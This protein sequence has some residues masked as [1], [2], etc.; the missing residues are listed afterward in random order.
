MNHEMLCNPVP[1]ADIPGQFLP[2]PEQQH[3]RTLLSV[4]GWLAGTEKTFRRRGGAL[5]RAPGA[6]PQTA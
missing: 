4:Q 3:H 6:P 1:A 2:G 5:P